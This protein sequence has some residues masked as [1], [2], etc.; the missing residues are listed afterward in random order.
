MLNKYI[1][2]IKG[3]PN[4]IDGLEHSICNM[5]INRESQK[6][7]FH[8]YWGM[9]S[10]WFPLI[11]LDDYITA[12][13]RNDLHKIMSIEMFFKRL[14]KTK[15]Y[16]SFYLDC[17]NRN[18]SNMVIGFRTDRDLSEVLKIIMSNYNVCFQIVQKD[19]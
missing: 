11:L 13:L 19:Y 2:Y 4:V 18:E 3:H 9:K 5:S 17:Y 14:L 6:S 10:N 15:E 7:T 1:I 12:T 16:H 8:Y